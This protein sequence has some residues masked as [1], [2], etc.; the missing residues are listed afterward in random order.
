MKSKKIELTLSI[1][2]H[3]LYNDFRLNGETH[4]EL[5]KNLDNDLKYQLL[6]V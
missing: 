3:E 5:N 2:S 1:I 4:T 6:C